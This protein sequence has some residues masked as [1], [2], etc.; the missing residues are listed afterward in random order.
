MNMPPSCQSP[1]L[2]AVEQDAFCAELF[3][4]GIGRL[5]RP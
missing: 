5:S 4:L 3:R 1:P 2:V